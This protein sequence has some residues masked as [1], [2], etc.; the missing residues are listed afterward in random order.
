[1]EKRQEISA[2]PNAASRHDVERVTKRVEALDVDFHY[3]VDKAGLSR[4]TGFSGRRPRSSGSSGVAR[5]FGSKKTGA[6]KNPADSGAPRI[7]A[8][9]SSSRI[10]PVLSAELIARLNSPLEFRP[11]H[12]GRTAFGYEATILPEICEALLDARAAR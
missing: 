7:P 4:P 1:M 9:L 8:F 2:K 3:A 5:A 12:G 10:F 11:M 6:E